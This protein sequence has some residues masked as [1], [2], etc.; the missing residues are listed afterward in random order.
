[1]FSPTRQRRKS[2]SFQVHSTITP[3]HRHRDSMTSSVQFDLH[4]VIKLVR[5]PLSYICYG[6]IQANICQERLSFSCTATPRS[7]TPPNLW[8]LLSIRALCNILWSAG[9]RNARYGSP[10]CYVAHRSCRTPIAWLPTNSY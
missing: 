2:T 10:V 3:A 9:M 4:S 1:M 6:Y 5:S 7:V 8:A